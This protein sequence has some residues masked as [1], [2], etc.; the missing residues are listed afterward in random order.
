[1]ASEPR[2]RWFVNRNF[3]LRVH[4]AE[5][6]AAQLHRLGL[7]PWDVRWLVQTH[8][9]FD[10]VGGLKFFPNSEVLVSR[11]EFERPPNGAAPSLWPTWYRPTLVDYAAEVFGP[12]ETSHVL[13]RAG[14]VRL[15]PTPG[16]THGHQSVVL[17]DG[18]VTYFFAGDAAFS[19]TGMLRG[20][21]AGISQDVE[22]ARRTSERTRELTRRRPVVFL[23]THDPLSLTRL[24]DKRSVPG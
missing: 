9:H 5:E 17:E 19:E 18:G 15:G 4:P 6:V 21:V 24:A 23:P 14:D 13:T 11:R 22:A 8:L 10:H 1:M 16:H 2:I 3:R 20:E 7:D 12:F